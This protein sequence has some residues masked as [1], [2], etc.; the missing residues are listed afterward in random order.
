M[1]PKFAEIDLKSLRTY[2]IEHQDDDE[3]FNKFVDRLKANASSLVYPSPNTSK[4]IAIMEQSIKGKVAALK[5]K[6]K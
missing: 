2:V 5:Y 6:I 3:A 4:N 1:N